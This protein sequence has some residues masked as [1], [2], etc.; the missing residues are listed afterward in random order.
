MDAGTTVALP[1]DYVPTFP[2]RCLWCLA[3][4]PPLTVPAGLSNARRI[5]SSTFAP[6]WD[7][8]TYP[9]CLPVQVPV[10]EKCREELRKRVRR[11]ILIV[12]TLLI[13]LWSL[14]AAAI[15][16]VYWLLF[17]Q[18]Q[19]PPIGILTI[20]FTAA[21]AL[22]AFIL[23][24]LNPPPILDISVRRGKVEYTFRDDKYATAFA[25]LNRELSGVAS[26]EIGAGTEN[27]QKEQLLAHN[28]RDRRLI[29]LIAVANGLIF[30]GLIVG[31]ILKWINPVIF[32]VLLVASM[33]ACAASVAVIVVRSHKP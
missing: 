9:P 30:G 15:A 28:R 24:L 4:E 17:Q 19:F 31:L 21:A 29:N 13:L 6:V 5:W 12:P 32:I 2:S 1:K 10:C 23:K 26:S 11:K 18:W 20:T 25:G 22:L 7:H 8:V 3:E 14:S 16:F 33:L 27:S